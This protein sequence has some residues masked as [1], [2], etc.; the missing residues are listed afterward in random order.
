MLCNPLCTYAYAGL[1][2]ALLGAC[3]ASEFACSIVARGVR[4]AWAI[5]VVFDR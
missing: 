5:K 2:L 1:L 3:L 4:F